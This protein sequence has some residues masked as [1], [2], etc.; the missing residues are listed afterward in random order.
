MAL[1]LDVF[2]P[3]R[4]N[5]AGVVLIISGGW[6]SSHESIPLP[7]PTLIIDG[8]T[9]RGYT[10]FAVV[11]SSQ[12]K[13]TILDMVRDIQ[14]AVR[15]VR[16]NAAHYGI[17]PQRIGITGASAGAHLALMQSVGGNDGDPKA[18]DEIETVSSR[19]QA[20]ACF[21]P[22]T[23]FLNYGKPHENALGRGI[24]KD[25]H[26]AFAFPEQDPDKVRSIG[27][28]ISPVNLVTRETPPTLLI[29][30]DK[31]ALVPIQQ[32]QSMVARLQ[33]AQVS[34]KLITK[35]GAGHGW[36]DMK[37]DMSA[38]ADWFDKYLPGKG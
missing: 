8:L 20:V 29:H 33:A 25:Y 9:A 19:I 34:A 14:R 27:W 11:H 2:T 6:F 38:I 1:T 12:P 26:A 30:G 17:D 23:D 28:I 7:V 37:N 10:V 21:F 5:G 16:Y 18:K 13:F 3:V 15:F 24:L 4:A 36:P 31:D 32:S 35:R 22:P